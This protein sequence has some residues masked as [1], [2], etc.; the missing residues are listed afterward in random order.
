MKA[1]LADGSL[2]RQIQSFAL[3]PSDGGRFEFTVNG[4]LVYSKLNLGR[5]AEPD[6]VIGLLRDYLAEAK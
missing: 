6:E 5:H 3:V 1:I 4:E 2:E